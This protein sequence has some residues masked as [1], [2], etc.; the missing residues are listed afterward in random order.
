[1]FKY[2]GLIFIIITCF[3]A[4]WYY[5]LRLKFRCEFLNSFKDFLST[6]ETNMKYNS[7]EIFSLVKKSAPENIK[8]VF[9]RDSGGGF[10]NYWSLCVE[11]I[12]LHFALKKDDYNL[13]YEF[14]RLLGTTDIEGQINHINLYKE[15]LENNINN[16][17]IEL[18]Q[19]SK[20][21]KTLGL[22]LGITIA[23]L[24]F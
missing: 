4:G 5:S 10:Q 2:I 17:N 9:E 7:A 23:L 22:F 24:L 20:L 8:T 6:L 19:K 16:S 18:K 14:G 13:L 11:N 12:P 1:M 21:S 3:G 15:L